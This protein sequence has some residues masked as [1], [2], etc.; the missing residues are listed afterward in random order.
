MSKKESSCR[1]VVDLPEAN[2]ILKYKAEAVLILNPHDN[3]C[4]KDA[5][6]YYFMFAHN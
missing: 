3:M 6:E 4:A 1:V 2:Q 5:Q